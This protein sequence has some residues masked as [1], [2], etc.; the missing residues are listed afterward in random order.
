MNDNILSSVAF[1]MGELCVVWSNWANLL[2]WVSINCERW[3][4]FK[5]VAKFLQRA[6]KLSFLLSWLVFGFGTWVFKFLTENKDGT[7]LEEN[8]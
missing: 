8:A 7:H 4:M 3:L 6:V 5:R 2:C 1:L